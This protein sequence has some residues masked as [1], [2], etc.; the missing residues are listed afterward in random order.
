[1]YNE[2]FGLWPKLLY[3]GSRIKSGM[4]KIEAEAYL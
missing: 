1:M 2:G 3:S 4:T